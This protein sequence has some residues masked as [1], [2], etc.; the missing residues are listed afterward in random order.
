MKRLTVMMSVVCIPSAAFAGIQHARTGPGAR[1]GSGDTTVG[2]V[3]EMA[4][5]T[6]PVGDDRSSTSL[7]LDA[8][9]PLGPMPLRVS[10]PLVVSAPEGGESGLGNV[11]VGVAKGL[12]LG[13]GIETALTLGIDLKLPTQGNDKV[14]NT[15]AYR[16]AEFAHK[17]TTLNPHGSFSID[18]PL[19]DGRLDLDY[20]H[21]LHQ[22]DNDDLDFKVLRF[23]ATVA[24]AV[25]PLAQVVVGADWMKSLSDAPEGQ[26]NEATTYARFGVRGGAAVVDYGLEF[27]FALSGP[28]KDAEARGMG[29]VASVSAGF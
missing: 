25:I 3:I 4:T 8:Q 11:A 12:E 6:P 22:T 9:M 24:V 18:T 19:I 15:S 2:A 20:L 28:E 10:V 14:V 27:N 5:I 7:I 16:G 26:D 17:L 1:T 23:G 21:G 29:I 13:L